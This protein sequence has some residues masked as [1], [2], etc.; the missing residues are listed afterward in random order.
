MRTITYLGLGLLVCGALV[1]V[2][3]SG[4]FDSTLA[5]RG[6]SIDTADDGDALVGVDRSELSLSVDDGEFTC[7][8][9]SGSYCF[10]G[11]FNYDEVLLTITDQSTQTELED[12]NVAGISTP[13][14]DPPVTS[15]EVI[16]NDDQHIVEGTV[17]CDADCTGGITGSAC[18][19]FFGS[20]TA[21]QPVNEQPATA[22]IEADGETISV[23]LDRTVDVECEAGTVTEPD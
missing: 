14:G 2:A 18:R 3:S 4:A 11:H 17:Q 16:S 9:S 7:T 8:D 21:E 12:V 10:D 22:E 15:V 6:V 5:D 20:G 19:G 23:D 13:D 1:F